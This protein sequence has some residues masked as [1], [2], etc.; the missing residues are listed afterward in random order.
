MRNKQ[1]GF[2]LKAELIHVIRIKMSSSTEMSDIVEET[3]MTCI[4]SGLICHGAGRLMW[5]DV[6]IT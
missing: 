5:T 1:V 3:H 6:E 4:L 2:I